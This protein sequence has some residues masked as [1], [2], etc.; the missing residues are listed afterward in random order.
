VWEE[1]K[2][3]NQQ[4]G[5]GYGPPK[6]YSTTPS[7]FASPFYTNPLVKAENMDIDGS[8]ASREVRK[9]RER[10]EERPME[11]VTTI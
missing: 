7:L 10:E 9:E 1:R 11:T 5:K 6:K 4:E 3:R 8:R 2:D